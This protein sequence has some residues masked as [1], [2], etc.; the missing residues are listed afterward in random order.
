M[1]YTD[2]R[3]YYFGPNIIKPYSCEAGYGNPSGHCIRSVAFYATLFTFIVQAKSVKKRKTVKI[4]FLIFFTLLVCM[5]IISR[6][7]V[8]AHGLNQ[9]LHGGL[10]GFLLYYY[11]FIFMELNGND[12][13]QLLRLVEMKN[14][15]YLLLN[16]LALIPTLLIFFFKNFN[17]EEQNRWQNM[18]EMKCEKSNENTRFEKDA[19][20]GIASFFA[21]IGAFASL[22]FEY[23]YTFSEN[24]QNWTNYNFSQQIDDDSLLSN[25]SF[26]KDTQWNHTNTIKSFLRFIVVLILCVSVSLPF[27]FIPG[28]TNYALLFIFREFTS[29]F[30]IYLGLFYFFKCLLKAMK[31]VN[32]SVFVFSEQI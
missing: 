2:P 22:K 13:K 21:N 17:S 32:T 20:L 1:I 5:I 28:T 24:I 15:Y 7:I 30:L 26:D 3:P 29:S 16:F 8:G 18:V 6:I 19:L 27:K 10:L 4:I 9:I 14:I 25:L 11:F 23:Y 12:S 31:L